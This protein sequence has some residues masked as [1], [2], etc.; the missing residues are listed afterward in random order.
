MVEKACSSLAEADKA[1]KKGDSAL[2]TGLFKWT[3][4][5]LEASMHY[6]KAAKAYK[7]FG[8]K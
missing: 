7:Q 6:E 4:N 1:L 8:D 5:Y 2:K 3:P